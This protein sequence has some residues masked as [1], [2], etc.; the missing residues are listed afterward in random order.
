MLLSTL[1]ITGYYQT[2]SYYQNKGKNNAYIDFINHNMLIWVCVVASPEVSRMRMGEILFLFGY[3]QGNRVSHS[4][5]ARRY[6]MLIVGHF[7]GDW[8]PKELVRRLQK[9]IS[10]NDIQGE[11]YQ[12]SLHVDEEKERPKQQALEVKRQEREADENEHLKA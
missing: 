11:V 3:L 7:E 12:Q 1:N 5:N 10:A 2:A 4:I 8:T 9:V 6:R